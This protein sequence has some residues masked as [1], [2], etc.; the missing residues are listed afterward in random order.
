MLVQGIMQKG[1]FVL[2]SYTEREVMLNTGIQLGTK[3]CMVVGMMWHKFL[4]HGHGGMFCAKAYT[5][6][7]SYKLVRRVIKVELQTI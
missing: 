3:Y 2:C 1:H 7:L 5:V 6:T 4:G